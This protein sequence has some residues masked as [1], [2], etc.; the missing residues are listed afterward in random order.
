MWFF[1]SNCFGINI[2]KPPNPHNI[3][4]YLV[5]N[6]WKDF[7]ARPCSGISIRVSKL[8]VGKL[9]K[10]TVDYSNSASGVY[11]N[12]TKHRINS[13]HNYQLDVNHQQ[14]ET[15]STSFISARCTI[16]SNHMGKPRKPRKGFRN[17]E[18]ADCS[19]FMLD[20]SYHV[21]QLRKT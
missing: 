3:F 12:Y 2:I 6:L 8:A 13:I 16:F 20:V 4:K 14:Y 21:S 10:A 11:K 5:R 1:P 7:L 9:H 19:P 18:S 17:G 15:L